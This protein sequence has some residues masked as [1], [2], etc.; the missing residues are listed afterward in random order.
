MNRNDYT[1]KELVMRERA[2]MYLDKLVSGINPVD[3]TPIEANNFILNPK[4]K[5]CFQFLSDYIGEVNAKE[6]RRLQRGRMVN[7][8]NLTPEQKLH[9]PIVD[10]AISVSEFADNVNSIVDDETVKPLK[11]TSIT[12]WLVD[13]GFLTVITDKDGK[14]KKLPTQAGLQIGIFTE[15]RYSKKNTE[16]Q[17]VLYTKEA[18][19]FIADNIG[20]IIDKNNTQKT[21]KE[22]NSQKQ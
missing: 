22:L 4:I 8:F 15:T 9:I 12:A 18:Q 2:K 13:K 19:Q 3:N 5:N 6:C 17:A 14:N 16:Y 11:A 1:S 10:Q 7:P 21:T 20:E